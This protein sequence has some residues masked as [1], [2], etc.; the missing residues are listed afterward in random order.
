MGSTK[1]TLT[2]SRTRSPGDSKKPEQMQ[3]KLVVW[4]NGPLFSQKGIRV[5]TVSGVNCQGR[6]AVRV[7]LKKTEDETLGQHNPTGQR[8]GLG[9]VAAEEKERVVL[10]WCSE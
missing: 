2:K 7:G 3:G 9:Q 6:S 1:G 8:R 4:R 5:E 10:E